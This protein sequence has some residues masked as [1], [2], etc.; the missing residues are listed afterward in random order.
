MTSKSIQYFLAL[1]FLGLGGWCLI[2]PQMVEA[3]VF[4][5]AYQDMT[6]TSAVLM[7]CFGAQAVLAGTVIA[8]SEFKPRTFLIFGVV[9]SMPFFVFNFYFYYV[10]EMFTAW[11]LLDFAGNIGILTCGILGYR[12]KRAEELTDEV[13]S[14]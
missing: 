2:T 10:A 6:A 7:G 12:L 4:R 11:M 13:T 1:I 3:L 5:P 9:G 8:T 14:L